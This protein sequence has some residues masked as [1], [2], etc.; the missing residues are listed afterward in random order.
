L[1]GCSNLS[2][3]TLEFEDHHYYTD[4]DLQ[5][6]LKRYRSI[7]SNNKIILTTEKNAMRLELLTNF[8]WQNNLPVFILPIQVEFFD[9]DEVLFKEDLKKFLLEFKV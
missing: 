9:Q 1:S 6:L 3:Q 8:F 7:D 4:D 5:Q 2:L